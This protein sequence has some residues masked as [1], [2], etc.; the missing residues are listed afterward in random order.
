MHLKFLGVFYQEKKVYKLI[1][2][3]QTAASSAQERI[4][5]SR[6]PRD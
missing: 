2:P 5:Q 3:I 6:Q 4:S 1:A